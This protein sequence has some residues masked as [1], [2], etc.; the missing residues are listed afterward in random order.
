[1]NSAISKGVSCLAVP[2]C[3]S[4]CFV[5][6]VRPAVP[7]VISCSQVFTEST[8]SQVPADGVLIE[9]HSLTID[10]STMTGESE[11]VS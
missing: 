1:M 9:G 2:L 11:P 6:Y 8:V 5:N 7:G 10:E 4:A 3:N